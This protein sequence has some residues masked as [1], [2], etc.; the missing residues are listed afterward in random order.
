MVWGEW[1]MEEAG[2]AHSAATIPSFI[3]PIFVIMAILSSWRCSQTHWAS[4]KK[5]KDVWW[6]WFLEK[7]CGWRGFLWDNSDPERW[8]STFL[9]FCFYINIDVGERLAATCFATDFFFRVDFFHPNKR[10]RSKRWRSIPLQRLKFCPTWIFFFS[11]NSGDITSQLDEMLWRILSKVASFLFLWKESPPKFQ[12]TSFHISCSAQWGIPSTNPRHWVAPETL[13]Q[14]LTLS[15]KRPQ[16]IQMPGFLQDEMLLIYLVWTLKNS[17]LAAFFFLDLSTCKS[18]LPG[19]QP[20][21]AVHFP[22]TWETPK[23]PA[24]APFAFKKKGTNLPMVFPGWL[25]W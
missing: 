8:G 25:F 24:L 13:C 2:P 14:V 7:L 10:C 17:T 3:L 20:L 21:V 11:E 6:G 23:K 18:L 22:A 9:E 16:R 15:P 1:S 4:Q 5:E 19:K 12:V